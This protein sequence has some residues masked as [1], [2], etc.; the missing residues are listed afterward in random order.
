[1]RV[2]IVDD[3]PTLRRMVRLTLEDLYEVHEAEDAARAL[4][5]VAAHGP[6]D[7]VLLDQ[8]MPGMSGVALLAELRRIAPATR[9]VMLTAHASLDLASAALA[10]GASHFLAKP[11]TPALLRAAVAAARPPAPDAT[12]AAAGRRE[13]TI[14]LNGFAID[15]ASR[16]R[17][18]KDGSATHV[19]TVSQVVGGWT[20]EADVHIARDAF[21]TSG[22][23]DVAV[24]GRLA[25]L[26][27]RRALADRLW[28]EGMLPGAE[29]LRLTGVTAE[30]LAAALRDDGP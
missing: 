19:F 24:A 6:F 7:V 5:A 9:V 22:R 2:L 26:V 3:E 30:Q 27:A 15:A 28:R 29:G 13:H 20:M 23:P 17:V 12:P 11:M 4:E 16:A 1:M 25:G 18:E 10:G 8:K 21:R 14:T